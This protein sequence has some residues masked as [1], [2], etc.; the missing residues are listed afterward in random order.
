V[1]LPDPDPVRCQTR[2]QQAC[3]NVLN[4]DFAKVARGQDKA[5]VNCVKNN[6]L[7]DESASVCL[8][9]PNRGVDRV[10]DK[11]RA[12][13][14]RHCAE[15]PPG[16]G[17][18]D[19]DTVNEAAVAAELAMLSEVFG[20]DLD[21]ALVTQADDK[22]AAKCQQALIK[23]VHKCQSTQIKEFNRCK[24]TALKKGGGMSVEV[25][26]RCLG[27]D[28]KGKIAKECDPVYGRLATKV[29]PRACGTVDLSAAF[30]GCS[31]ADPGELASCVD[32]AVACRV[33]LG[34]DEAD[35]LGE[36]CD[37]FDDGVANASCQ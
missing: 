19:A 35:D 23:A 26:A 29:L 13:E 11:T 25:L 18:L 27:V 22:S 20:P 21:A 24:K 12:D 28:P 31:T 8:S 4:G 6:A 36:D 2:G 37:F 34:L 16:F 3:I 30:P 14:D 7:R 32:E 33:C 9:L 1:A 10:R 15:M 17:P 5:I